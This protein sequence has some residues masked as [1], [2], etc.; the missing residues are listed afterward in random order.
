MN[1]LLLVSHCRLSYPHP[2]T[3]TLQAGLQCCI[4]GLLFSKKSLLFSPT[5]P[6][7]EL[8]AVA[9]ESDADDDSTFSL[10]PFLQQ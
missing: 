4:A 1:N 8:P 3:H 10:S 7:Q 9:G 2:P 5:L 6:I